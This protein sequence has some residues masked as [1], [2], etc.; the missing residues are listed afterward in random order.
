MTVESENAARL[1]EAGLIREIEGQSLLPQ[2]YEFIENLD[3]ETL[4]CLV[5][6]AARLDDAGIPRRPLT[7]GEEGVVPF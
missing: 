2:Y 6:L 4:D 1:R 5:S 7:P 3:T